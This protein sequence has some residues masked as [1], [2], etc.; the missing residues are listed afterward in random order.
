[1]PW[2]GKTRPNVHDHTG[3]MP[4]KFSIALMH[5]GTGL[6]TP[7]RMTTY[8]FCVTMLFIAYHT[9]GSTEKYIL[10]YPVGW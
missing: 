4:E 6:T 2:C 3:E 10:K 9:T 5:V 8:H 1:M 7:R